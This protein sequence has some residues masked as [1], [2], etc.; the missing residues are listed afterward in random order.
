MAYKC[1]NCGIQYVETLMD[2]PYCGVP[3]LRKLQLINSAQ[4]IGAYDWVMEH[5]ERHIRSRNN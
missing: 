4:K 2:C 3:N 1:R 5:K